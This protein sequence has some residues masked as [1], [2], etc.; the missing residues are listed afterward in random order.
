MTRKVMFLVGLGFVALVLVVSS[1]AR[2]QGGG[3]GSQTTEYSFD[4]DVVQ[5]DLVRPDGEIQV[6]RHKGKQSSLIKVRD[7]FIKEML[8]SVE[9]L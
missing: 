9:D 1:P 4:D 6:G 8:K 2:A 3:G 5:G 7:N